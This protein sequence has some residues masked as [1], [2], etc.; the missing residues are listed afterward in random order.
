MR[1]LVIC[2]AVGFSVNALLLWKIVILLE[3]LGNIL[4]A[5]SKVNRV[6]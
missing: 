3:W 1:L 2:I 6:G 4:N 5:I